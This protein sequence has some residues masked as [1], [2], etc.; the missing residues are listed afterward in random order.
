MYLCFTGEKWGLWRFFRKPDG[1]V[2]RSTG[3]GAGVE[4]WVSG[5]GML[6]F[7]ALARRGG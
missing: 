5:D 3:D 4:L 1:C 7:L 6:L 2:A